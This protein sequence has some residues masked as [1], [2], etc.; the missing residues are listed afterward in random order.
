[1]SFPNCTSDNPSK[2]TKP[3]GKYGLKER[4]VL[5]LLDSELAELYHLVL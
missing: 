3:Q 4:K 1:M 5:N 2:Y